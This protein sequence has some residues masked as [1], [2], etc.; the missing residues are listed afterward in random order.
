MVEVALGTF[1]LDFH[2]EVWLLDLTPMLLRTI[3]FAK[4]DPVPL[5]IVLLLRRLR[6]T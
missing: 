1:D 6:R 4:S 5:L 3:M 2:D